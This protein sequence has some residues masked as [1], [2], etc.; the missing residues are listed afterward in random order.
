[1][2][3]IFGRNAPCVGFSVPIIASRIFSIVL[4]T[5]V[6]LKTGDRYALISRISNHLIG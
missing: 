4:T 6:P 1:M 2:Q 5:V 3:L